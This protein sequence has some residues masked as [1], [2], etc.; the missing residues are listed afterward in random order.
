[1]Y[2]VL[3]VV[4][5]PTI[6]SNNPVYICSYTHILLCVCV[7]T[8]TDQLKVIHR[9]KASHFRTTVVLVGFIHTTFLT[10]LSGVLAISLPYT[11]HRLLIPAAFN[12]L[13]HFRARFISFSQGRIQ[14]RGMRSI[15][16]VGV[17]GAIVR[18]Q[19]VLGL[20]T[21]LRKVAKSVA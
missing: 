11:L 16:V 18:C 19:A 9:P 20:P 21:N 10:E 2:C 6:I 15:L 5:T 17:P 4:K 7:C 3:Q 12:H 13:F 14:D 8:Y 1:M